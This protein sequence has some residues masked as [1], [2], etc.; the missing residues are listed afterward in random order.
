MRA[1]SVSA[2]NEDR[3]QRLKIAA[4]VARPYVI[5]GLAGGLLVVAFRRQLTASEAGRLLRSF[6]KTGT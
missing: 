2:V 5:G 4:E 3:K 6:R 1:R